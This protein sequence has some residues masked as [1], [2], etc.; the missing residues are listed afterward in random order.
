[1]ALNPFAVS[2][3]PTAFTDPM[4]VLF[5]SLALLL[6]L[7]ARPFWAGLWLGAAIMTKQ[8]GLL[9]LPLVAGAGWIVVREGSV[10]ETGFLIKTRFL[11]LRFLVGMALVTLPILYWDSLRWAVAPSPWDLGVQHYG[12]FS[13]AP[14][15]EWPARAQAWAGLV[16]QLGGSWLVWGGLAGLW[17]FHGW[18]RR[19]HPP[20]GERNATHGRAAAWGWILLWTGGFLA[21]H[22]VANVQVWDRYLLPLAPVMALFSGWTLAATLADVAPRPRALAVSLAAFLLLFPAGSAAQGRTPIGGDH[23]AYEGLREAIAWVRTAAPGEAILYHRELGWDYRFYLFDEVRAG[24]Y[25]LRWLPNATALA[26]DVTKHPHPRAFYIQPDWAPLRDNARQ[27]PARGIE[28]VEAARFGRMTVYELRNRD[29]GF[30]EW[31]F[32]GDK[33]Y[34]KFP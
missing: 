34:I 29:T 1:M 20:A 7:R 15:G 10:Q 8:Q 16:W 32:C 18:R 33:S 27:L 26:D 13:L 4:L 28:R 22:V 9:Y 2:F 21:F 25:E 5:G 12:G 24:R 30:C 6:A 3:A 31:C 19:T 17:A 14:P 11:W 23:G